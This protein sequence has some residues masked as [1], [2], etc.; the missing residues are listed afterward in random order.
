[1]LKL[2]T[3]RFV[4]VED[5]DLS[6]RQILVIALDVEANIQTVDAQSADL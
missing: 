3:V 6:L 4:H 5:F 2:L 1:L